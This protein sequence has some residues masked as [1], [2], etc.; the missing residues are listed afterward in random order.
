[1]NPFDLRWLWRAIRGHSL[2]FALIFLLT[3][4]GVSATDL[5]RSSL[6]PLNLS[7]WTA[8]L[9]PLVLIWIM[10]RLEPV[11][12]PSAKLRRWI[13]LGVVALALTVVYALPRLLPEEAPARP[14]PAEVSLAQSP[15]PL[16]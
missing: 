11:I 2:T 13:A 5:I 1:M 16:P 3:M 14:E 7:W 10:L 6:E 15:R 8:S 4:V 12:V 9:A